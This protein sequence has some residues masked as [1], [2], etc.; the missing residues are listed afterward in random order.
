MIWSDMINQSLHLEIIWSDMTNQSL[1][2]KMIWSDM[3]HMTIDQSITS[4]GDDL[5]WHGLESLLHLLQH[6]LDIVG[7]LLPIRGVEAE[8]R[9]C[10]IRGESCSCRDLQI[11][12]SC[13]RPRAKNCLDDSFIK[14][15]KYQVIGT[16][17]AF[18][19]IY[20]SITS[21]SEFTVTTHVCGGFEP[22]GSV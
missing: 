4:P 21:N 7:Q 22:E 11:N 6:A 8:T 19:R 18:V 14:I 2:L 16:P 10:K 15:N 13:S 12:L 1:H 20:S 9:D 3:S 17:F 5:V